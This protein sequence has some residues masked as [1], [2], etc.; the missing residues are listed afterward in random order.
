MYPSC[1]D[2]ASN[3]IAMIRLI[4][5]NYSQLARRTKFIHSESKNVEYVNTADRFVIE[6]AHLFLFSNLAAN[7]RKQ[8]FYFDIVL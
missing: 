2:V 1:Q 8:S 5:E 6:K 4:A 3:R 7:K